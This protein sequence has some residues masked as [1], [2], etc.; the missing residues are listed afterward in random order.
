MEST[1][2][3]NQEVNVWQEL[4]RPWQTKRFQVRLAVFAL[5]FCAA[6]HAIL[7]ATDHYSA[8]AAFGA[9]LILIAPVVVTLRLLTGKLDA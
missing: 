5:F 7:W 9:S 8:S 6:H 4:V 1:K 3:I 2:S